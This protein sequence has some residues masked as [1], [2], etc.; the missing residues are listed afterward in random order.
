MT[1]AD[2]RT[3]RFGMLSTANIG[4]K[5]VA[6]AIVAASG[7]ELVAIGSRSAERARQVAAE[8]GAPRA[9]GSYQALLDDPDVDAVYIP[10]PNSLHAPWT[11]RAARAGKHVLCEKPLALDADECRSMQA[12]ADEA[13]VVLMEAFMYRFHPRTEAL[14]SLCAGG[15]LGAIRLLRSTFTFHVR[16]PADIRLDAALGGGSVMD[17][18]CYCVN[19]VRTVLAD[20]PVA[21]QSTARWSGSGP[22][23][24]VDLGMTG[25]LMFAGGVA[26]QFASALDVQR[27]EVLQVV[28][29]EGR[30]T[31]EGA[32][33][34]GTEPTQLVVVRPDGSRDAW[35]FDGVDEYRLMV[36]HFASCVREGRRP[37]YDAGEAAANARAIG[38][39]LAS[40]R[41]GGEPVPL[42]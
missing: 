37:R 3:L 13:G 8:L 1:S 41:R 32:F 14:V 31:L 42:A 28:G 34:P 7:C 39:L 15:G 25:T 24:G 11:V 5:V 4:R 27:E 6:P 21:V 17:V 35:D 36:E 22:G 10:L 33:L 23:A 19:A 20:E 9:H 2:A 38:A 29:T 26:A 18:G 40:A 30:V 12:A 16:D